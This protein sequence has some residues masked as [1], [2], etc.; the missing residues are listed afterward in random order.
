MIWDGHGSKTVLSTIH[1]FSIYCFKAMHLAA[2]N[3]KISC[4][5]DT[6]TINTKGKALRNLPSA[7]C[8]MLTICYN[9]TN[10]ETVLR[11]L[12][13][14]SLNL[15]QEVALIKAA[16]TH[17]GQ[18]FPFI[19]TRIE[20]F[21]NTCCTTLLLCLC[22]YQLPSI[23]PREFS[24][25]PGVTEKSSQPV[26]TDEQSDISKNFQSFEIVFEQVKQYLIC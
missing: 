8:P 14:Q 25:L 10:F 23:L 12:Q 3:F 2:T 11:L 9:G 4:A 20:G 15:V 13:K 22:L 6:F 26:P 16:G 7:T 24:F 18:Q 1:L 21:Q 19:S 17:L 5:S